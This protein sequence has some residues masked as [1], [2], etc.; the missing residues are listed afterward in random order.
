M[1]DA[2]TADAEFERM[3]NIALPRGEILRTLAWAAAHT[4]ILEGL[5]LEGVRLDRLPRIAR[6]L[7]AGTY[8][9]SPRAEREIL[10]C[11]LHALSFG[12]DYG[13]PHHRYQS[14]IKGML[15]NWGFTHSEE[16]KDLVL[17]RGGCLESPCSDELDAA[18]LSAF[19]KGLKR[20]AES[21]AVAID[22]LRRDE[23]ELAELVAYE[24]TKEARVANASAATW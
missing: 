20:A 9:P 5:K 2:V 17:E 3:M 18:A 1:K 12:R 14:K 8:T 11:L 24:A 21:R 22:A 6:E 7:R 13:A 23:E 10:E 4:N 19:H 15:D 16:F